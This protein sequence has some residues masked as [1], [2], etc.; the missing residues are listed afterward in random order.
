VLEVVF[1][2]EVTVAVEKDVCSAV[3]VLTRVAEYE[4]TTLGVC[5]Y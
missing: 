4:A 5:V 2:C 1:G 3:V